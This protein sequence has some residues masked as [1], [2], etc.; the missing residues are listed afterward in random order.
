MTIIIS[1]PMKKLFQVVLLFLLWL[2]VISPAFAQSEGKTL[3]YQERLEATKETLQLR[4]E[5]I[6]EQVQERRTTAAAHLSERRKERIRQFF[7]RL[8][9]RMR[10]ALR[11]LEKLVMRMESRLDKI[12]SQDESL[13]VVP[14]RETLDD[15]KDRLE[16][17]S[18]ALV[19]AENSLEDILLAEDPKEAFADV[20]S[21]IKEIKNQLVEVHRLLVHMIGEIRGLRVGQME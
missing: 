2:L 1:G 16:R 9:K 17:V 15:A 20:K 4:R 12:E 13:D 6:R 21:L 10:A 8:V 5:T 11:R 7:N 3:S 19:Q 14:I 18:E